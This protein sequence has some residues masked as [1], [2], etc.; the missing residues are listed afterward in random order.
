MDSRIEK[1]TNF[2]LLCILYVI[3]V[4][5]R[6]SG[7]ALHTIPITPDQAV[8]AIIGYSMRPG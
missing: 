2:F 1:I 5:K 8:K 3:T 4:R 7:V 6:Q